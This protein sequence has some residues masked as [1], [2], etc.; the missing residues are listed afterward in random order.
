MKAKILQREHSQTIKNKT[1]KVC[2]Q[3]FQYFLAE[4]YAILMCTLIFYKII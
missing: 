2:L 4:R 1:Q 3:V